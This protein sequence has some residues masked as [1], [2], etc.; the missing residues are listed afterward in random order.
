M[1]TGMVGSDFFCS[2]TFNLP[3]KTAQ[4]V[5]LQRITQDFWKHKMRGLDENTCDLI[6]FR[7]IEFRTRHFL[8][9]SPA[10][11]NGNRTAASAATRISGLEDRSP[12]ANLKLI[13]GGLCSAAYRRKDV[14]RSTETVTQKRGSNAAT[15][16]S[17][18]V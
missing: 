1:N 15:F 6:F 18:S 7:G 3:H 13:D 5:I 14:S 11:I 8:N 2:Y 12:R 10:T 16:D 9:V 4:F 17:F